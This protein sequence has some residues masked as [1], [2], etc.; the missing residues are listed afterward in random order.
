[1]DF[2]FEYGVEFRDARL[3]ENVRQDLDSYSRLGNVLSR[4]ALTELENVANELSAEFKRFRIRPLRKSNA[5]FLRNCGPQITSFC[6]LRS[7]RRSAHSLFSEAMLYILAL[8]ALPTTELHPSIQSF[9]RTCVT[10][11]WELVIDG[12]YFGKRWKHAVQMRSS[13]SNA[14]AKLFSTGSVGR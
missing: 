13:I 9:C 3:V 11:L 5:A 6:G 12:Q 2:N 14:Q 1:M 7:E 8:G 4:D 10:I